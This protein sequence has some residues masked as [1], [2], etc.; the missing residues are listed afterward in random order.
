MD[1]EELPGRVCEDVLQEPPRAAPA[2]SAELL[3]SP[4]QPGEESGIKQSSRGVRTTATAKQQ[5]L[6][7]SWEALGNCGTSERSGMSPALW[8]CPN[9]G[10]MGLGWWE[11]LDDV[12]SFPPKPFQN[13]GI[14]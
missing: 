14:L 13:P 12:K 2:V 9:P 1:P 5:L 3:L 4:A 8:K 11:V 6:P 7:L 10:W